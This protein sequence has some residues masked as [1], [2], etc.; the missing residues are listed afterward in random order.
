MGGGWRG[1]GI[2]G[3]GFEGLGVI[4]VCLEQ[5]FY[6]SNRIPHRIIHEQQTIQNPDNCLSE[7][8]NA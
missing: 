2:R 7:A 6:S 4:C 8:Y 3:M 1:A 5:T